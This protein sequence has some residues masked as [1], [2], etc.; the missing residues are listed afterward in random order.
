M[1]PQLLNI[2]KKITINWNNK[3]KFYT[4]KKNLQRILLSKKKNFFKKKY[5]IK[6]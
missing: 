4:P 2:C 6:I 5:I 3:I 1:T